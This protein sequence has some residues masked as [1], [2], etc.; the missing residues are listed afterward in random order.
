M[1]AF[2]HHVGM[3]VRRHPASSFLTISRAKTYADEDGETRET[4]TAVFTGSMTL[5]DI[6]SPLALNVGE[7]MQIWIRSTEIRPMKLCFHRQ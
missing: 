7:V 1:E 5:G 6:T 4:E 2:H 3:R